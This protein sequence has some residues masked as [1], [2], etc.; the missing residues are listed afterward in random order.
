MLLIRSNLTTENNL[1]VEKRFIISKTSTTF[2][3]PDRNTW[4]TRRDKHNK[5]TRKQKICRHFAR[6]GVY[7]ITR[8]FENDQTIFF[9]VTAGN[10]KFVVSQ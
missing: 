6:E 7:Y 3:F 2:F 10:V 8:A 9:H 4:G 5:K 1:K